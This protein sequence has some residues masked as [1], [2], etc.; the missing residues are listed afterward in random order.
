VV[1]SVLYA[2]AH[3]SVA[4]EAAMQFQHRGFTIECSVDTAGVSY[5]G[6]VV[7]SRLAPDMENARAF[8]SGSLR[9][10][11]TRTQAI[12]YARFWAEMWCDEQQ[13]Q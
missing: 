11:P 3:H 4:A 8:R 10:F 6:Q 12:G 2:G 13:Y 5:V 1:E 9:A 7:I